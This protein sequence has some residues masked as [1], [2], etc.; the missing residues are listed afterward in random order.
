MQD[1]AQRL[2][3]ILAEGIM[4]NADKRELKAAIKARN[5]DKHQL[6]W[7]RSRIFDLSR[8][9]VASK[10]PELVIAWLEEANKLLLPDEEYNEPYDLVTFSPG[11]DGKNLIKNQLAS[12]SRLLDICVFTISDNEISNVIIQ[13]HRRGVKVRILTD[14]LKQYDAGSD[15]QILRNAGVTV[16]V[17]SSDQHMHHKFAIID[18]IRL[19][20]GSYNWT[21]SAAEHNFENLMVSSDM[22]LVKPFQQEFERLWTMW[23]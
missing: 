16:R 6:A 2:A 19:L 17:D 12:A 20:N 23:G 1:I 18:G 3:D 21:R 5:P 10:S 8:E 11:V 9:S 15:I 14:E 7:L 13:A 4:T 22:G